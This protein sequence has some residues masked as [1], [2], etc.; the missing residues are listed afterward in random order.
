MNRVG[1]LIAASVL[2]FGMCGC[3]PAVLKA[4]RYRVDK[5]SPDWV[6][7]FNSNGVIRIHLRCD[8]GGPAYIGAEVRRG[9]PIHIRPGQ[10]VEWVD[11]KFMTA[12]AAPIAGLRH[13]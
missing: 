5:T 3:A 4:P 8:A 9:R 10:W 6:A 7:V 11:T 13:C 1:G 2:A 12:V